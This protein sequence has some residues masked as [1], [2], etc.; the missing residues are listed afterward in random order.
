MAVSDGGV[1]EV[2]L[3]P[4]PLTEQNLR[5][6]IGAWQ[7]PIRDLDEMSRMTASS[8]SAVT[9]STNVMSGTTNSFS[10]QGDAVVASSAC[11]QQ[12]LARPRRSLGFTDICNPTFRGTAWDG[13]AVVWQ[14]GGRGGGP[15]WP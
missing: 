7:A 5:A 4:P 14:P 13:H 15:D 2:R 9:V 1:D 12:F 8:N 10:L 6:V 3:R 11:Y